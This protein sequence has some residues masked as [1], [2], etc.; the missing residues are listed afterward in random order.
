M[1]FRQIAR[2]LQVGHVSVMNWV[3][4]C[5]A[6]LPDAHIPEEADRVDMDELYTFIGKKNRICLPANMKL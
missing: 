4:A 6:G 5:T 1:G 2:Q 3:R